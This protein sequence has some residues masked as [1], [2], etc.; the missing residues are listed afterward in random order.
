MKPHFLI[1]TLS[2]FP[3]VKSARGEILPD[4]VLAGKSNVGK[5]S[6]I[7]HLFRQK[8]ARTSATPGKTQLINF[9]QIDDLFLLVD[10]PGYGFAKAS[11]EKVREWSE[12]IDGY[13]NKRTTIGLIL[14]LVDS[15]REFASEDVDLFDWAQEK[16]IPL[17]VIFT[18]TD[19]LKAS[20][21]EILVKKH[22]GALFYSIKD[23]KARLILESKIR[24]YICH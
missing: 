12:A 17:L 6:L 13:L 18:K 16:R 7:N 1:S 21:K 22:P 5:S 19:K 2:E 9:F 10:L 20:E 3:K 23:S 24:E 14:L 11:K 4:V 8:I 15:R